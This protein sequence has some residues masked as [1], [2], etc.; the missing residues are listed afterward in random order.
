MTFNYVLE[1][2][3]KYSLNVSSEIEKHELR[4]FTK[5][6][7]NNIFVFDF[8]PDNNLFKFIF[9][10]G[11]E[12][13]DDENNR[14]VAKTLF[15]LYNM[16]VIGNIIMYSNINIYELEINMFEYEN[17]CRN[18][19][20]KRFIRKNINSRINIIK[21]ITFEQIKQKLGDK[22][23]KLDNELFKILNYKTAEEFD[24]EFAAIYNMPFTN[25][26]EIRR[27]LFNIHPIRKFCNYILCTLVLQPEK[28][29]H[30]GKRKINTQLQSI[31]V[32]KKSNKSNIFLTESDSDESL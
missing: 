6:I 2:G 4:G 11:F 3:A 15:L 16:E 22:Y 29:S 32:K 25:F 30:L 31:S 13:I 10:N 7:E 23:K 9:E 8:Q 19:T 18:S 28:S 1:M 12:I 14:K 21:S 27:N 20:V 5:D 17:N 26:K 24:K